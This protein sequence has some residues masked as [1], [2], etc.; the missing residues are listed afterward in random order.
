MP[1]N[2]GRALRTPSCRPGAALLRRQASGVGVSVSR[3][4]TWSSLV[5]SRGMRLSLPSKIGINRPQLPVVLPESGLRQHGTFLLGSRRKYMRAARRRGIVQRHTTLLPINGPTPLVANGKSSPLP[6][7]C[8]NCTMPSLQHSRDAEEGQHPPRAKQQC[9]VGLAGEVV[10]E[11]LAGWDGGWRRCSRTH[12]MYGR[13]I[14]F[15]SW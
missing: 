14:W 12:L 11:V 2:R 1:V 3:R 8:P 6:R 7:R 4:T 13:D 5:C 10:C 9:P 15:R